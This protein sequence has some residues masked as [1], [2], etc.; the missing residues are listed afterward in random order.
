MNG[1]LQ[2]AFCIVYVL[3]FYVA[4]TDSESA[5]GVLQVADYK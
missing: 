4:K 1:L 3:L 5:M 2:S